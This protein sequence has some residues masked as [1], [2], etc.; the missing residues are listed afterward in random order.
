MSYAQPEPMRADPSQAKAELTALFLRQRAAFAVNGAPPL[1]ERL[2]LLRQLA[3][4]VRANRDAIADAAS[5]DFGNRSRHETLLADIVTT[6]NSIDHAARRLKGWMRP[7]RVPVG[8]D[9]FPGKARVLAQPKGVVGIIGPWNYPFQLA[10]MPLAAAL[11]AGNRVMIKP[12]ELAPRTAAL[13]AKIA[14]DNFAPEQVAVVQG[15]PA[16]GEAFSM[17]PFDHLLYTGSSKV[18][19]Y[20]MRAAADNLTPVTLE[21][22]GKSPAIV[23]EDAALPRAA[24]SIMHGKLLNAG[25]TCIAP[26]YVLVPERLVQPFVREA[27]AAVKRLY[28]RLAA[29]PDYTAIVN[30]RHYRRLVG[31]VDEAK[32]HGAQVIELNPAGEPLFPED[33]R[34]PP[35]LILQPDPHLKVMQEEIFGP[36][37]AVCGYRTL[38][39]A[40]A[41]V[42]ARPRPLA[43]Y[44]FGADRAGREAVLSRTV[45]GGVTVNDTLLHVAVEGLP[46]GGIGASGMGAYH[47]KAGFDTFSHYKS[48]FEQARWSGVWLLRPPYGRLADAILRFLIGK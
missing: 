25:Q 13:L 21:L 39:D 12:S 42:N 29:N 44:Y 46:F 8:R 40:I 41:F 10:A 37:L 15:G 38:D 27:F 31:Y 24:R 9:L 7:R 4:A 47:G 18:G 23:A 11:G 3:I 22:G 26:D 36:I 35:T 20:V 45:S 28:P 16:V 34:L 17:L 1:E 43:L 33:R 5:A 14:A 48:V 6:L 2:R 32:S 19:H 30:E